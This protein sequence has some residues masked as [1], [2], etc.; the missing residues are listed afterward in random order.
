MKWLKMWFMKR[1]LRQKG[2][3]LMMIL[4]GNYKKHS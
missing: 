4:D 1:K 2:E 3:S